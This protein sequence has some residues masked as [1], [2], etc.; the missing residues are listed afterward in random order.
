MARLP[1]SLQGPSCIPLG[2]ESLGF[3]EWW[4]SVHQKGMWGFQI[5]CRDSTAAQLLASELPSHIPTEEKFRLA[6]CWQGRLLWRNLWFSMESRC[7]IASSVDTD[8]AHGN[9]FGVRLEAFSMESVF[10]SADPRKCF[11]MHS[12]T[13]ECSFNSLSSG[14][15][16]SSGLW[17]QRASSDA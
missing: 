12:S 2:L 9:H 13:Q 1:A 15:I 7:L 11:K 8:L 4:M 6:R 10:W 16:L 14:K 3:V 5:L 17:R